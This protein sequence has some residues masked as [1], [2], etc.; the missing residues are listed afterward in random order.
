MAENDIASCPF[1]PFTD[2]DPDFVSQHIEFCHPETG[3]SSSLLD[4]LGSA[5]QNSVRPPDGEYGAD[6]FIDCPHGC[7][8]TIASDELSSHLDLHVAEDIALDD[9]GPAPARST[10]D[11]Y[12][13]DDNDDPS[14]DDEDFH[15]MG[16][17]Y[18]GG[19]RGMQRDSSR[20][21]TAKPPRPHSPPR[22][23][24]ADGIKRL[25]VFVPNQL[26]FFPHN[27]VSLL[28]FSSARSWVPMPT[29]KKCHCGSRK[30]WKKAAAHQ[31]RPKSHRTAN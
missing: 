20:A 23:T 13:H 21:N 11:K 24:N 18:K 9:L 16:N 30:C 14:F 5:G 1:C 28:T 6:K 26:F 7:G 4:S 17:A 25:G 22:T 8:E 31:N 27:K 29:R 2:S 10:T 15:D 3:V 12:A 19:K